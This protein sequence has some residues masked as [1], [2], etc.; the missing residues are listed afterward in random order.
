MGRPQPTGI[1]TAIIITTTTITAITSIDGDAAGPQD[2]VSPA[3]AETHQW[4]RPRGSHGALP[5]LR[6]KSERYSRRTQA[7]RCKLDIGAADDVAVAR[8]SGRGLQLLAWVGM[9]CRSG[10]GARC[11]DA[12]RLDRGPAPPWRR[13]LRCDPAGRGVARA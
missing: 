4:L 1:A 7:R 2:D 3:E 6:C 13:T 9:G 5:A 10:H 12:G 11:R 8:L